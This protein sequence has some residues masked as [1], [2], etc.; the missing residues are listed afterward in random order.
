MSWSL[1]SMWV[2]SLG[3]QIS[4]SELGSQDR[5]A[6]FQIRFCGAVMGLLCCYGVEDRT[7]SL[8]GWIRATSTG[9]RLMVGV[10]PEFC[11]WVAPLMWV[12][13][14][15]DLKAKCH[16]RTSGLRSR[17]TQWWGKL[18]FAGGGNGFLVG[19]K[20]IGDSVETSGVGF[21]FWFSVK[22]FYCTVVQTLG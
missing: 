2:H 17:H 20:H 3:L 12:N 6:N 8:R 19:D 10:V 14:C 22:R 21:W 18:W 9:V 7:L 1:G 15:W 11:E 16:L 5:R 13:L 4:C